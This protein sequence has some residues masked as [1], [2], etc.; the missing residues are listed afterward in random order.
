M[1]DDYLKKSYWGHCSYGKL[2]NTSEILNFS[3][4]RPLGRFFL[5]VAMS[6]CLHV[7]PFPCGFYASFDSSLRERA[8]GERAKGILS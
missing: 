4:N 6:V 8:L 5:V 2:E 1:L 3:K 7:V